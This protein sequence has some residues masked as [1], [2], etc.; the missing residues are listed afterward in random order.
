M[1]EGM[2]MLDQLEDIIESSKTVPLIGKAMIDKDEV[3]DIIQELRLK[4]PDDLKQAKWIK[5]ERQR[6]LLEAQKEATSIIKSAE[7]KII[8]MI[9]ENEITKKANEAAEEII[10]NANTRAREIRNATKQYIDDA[11][12]DSE[13]VLE[14]TLS[15]LRDNRLAMQQA[16]IKKQVKIEEVVEI[17]E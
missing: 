12:A 5:G 8:S 10:K 7:D 4:M 6:I 2:E 3:L 13:M 11:L 14:R 16:N 17:E 15:T 9:N 1:M